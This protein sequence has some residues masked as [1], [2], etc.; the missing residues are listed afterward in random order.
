[1]TSERSTVIRLKPADF[2]TLRRIANT[3]RLKHTEAASVLIAGWAQLTEQQRLD[4]IR[5]P[6]PEP[7]RS[8]R[9]EP[10]PS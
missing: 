1:M 4:A 8:R 7:K 6:D 3:Y 9:R 10:V 5:Q 2:T